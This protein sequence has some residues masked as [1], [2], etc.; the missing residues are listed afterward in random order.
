MKV[1]IVA[2]WLTDLGGAEKVLES[3][4]RIFP[5]SEFFTTVYIKDNFPFLKKSKVNTTFLD[6]LPLKIKKRHQIL[7]PFLPLSIESLDLK[8]FDLVISSSSFVAKG[9]ITSEN[10]LHI[11][12]CHTP[13]RYFWDEWQYFLKEGLNIPSFLQPLKF[14]F[15]RL[16]TKDRIW[17][18]ISAQRPDFY[19][20]NS[21][22]VVKRIKK[23]YERD[24]YLL[25][26][27]VDYDKFKKGLIYEKK[28]YYIAMG[29]LIPYKKF[30]LLIKSFLLLPNKKLKII[31][32]GPEIDYLKNLIKDSKNIEIL[33]FVKN[34]EVIKLLGGAKAFLF[35]QNE[36]A[37]ITQMEALSTGTPCIALNKGGSLGIVS[38]KNGIL[39]DKQ[40]TKDIIEAVKK[41]ELKE[42][43][44]LENREAISK[45]MEK[46]NKVN[47]E[48]NFKNL[49]NKIINKK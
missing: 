23:Y 2:D 30:D 9:V 36:D 28:D 8:N 20:G 43:Y 39:F 21:E 29:R 10:T 26:P 22:Y 45:S 27:P 14:I 6:S 34:D 48:S 25:R 18:F 17:D 44:F 38:E 32:R 31:G 16:F 13:T 11:C 4:L 19:I 15:P 49:I 7:Y 40:S 42:K 41:F 1:A 35:P 33:G 12:Y 3:F 37:G 24:S 46:Y 5:N 47:F